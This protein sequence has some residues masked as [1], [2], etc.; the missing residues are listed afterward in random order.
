MELTEIIGV[1][2]FAIAILAAT[3]QVAFAFGHNAGHIAGRAVERR[4]AD[5]RVKGVLESENARQPK[6]RKRARLTYR[7]VDA[8]R[9]GEIRFCNS[10]L[11][12]VEVLA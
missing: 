7:K 6:E 2:L 5:R 3:W 12:G 8:R 10:R 11:P 9:V 4:L 1:G